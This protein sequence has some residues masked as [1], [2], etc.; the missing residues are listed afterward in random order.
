MESKE[1][2]GKSV[3]EALE[4]ALAEFNLPIEQIEYEVLEKES[5]GFLGLFNSKPARISARIKEKDLCGIASKFLA[6]VL[7]AM[8]VKAEIKTEISEAKDEISIDLSGEE[9]KVKIGAISANEDIFYSDKPEAFT[10]VI[11]YSW[12]DEKLGAEGKFN[13]IFGNVASG[14]VDDFVKSFNESNAGPLR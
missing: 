6:E 4:S 5:T 3:E 9:I 10:L 14:E 7:E 8:G 12:M 11:P 1:F 13:C 2:T